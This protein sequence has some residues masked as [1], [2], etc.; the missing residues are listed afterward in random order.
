[1]QRVNSIVWIEGKVTDFVFCGVYSSEEDDLSSPKGHR[2]THS[3]LRERFTNIS[4]KIILKRRRMN[5]TK[6]TTHR[7]IWQKI[8]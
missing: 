1:M 8:N 7:K 2:N 4:G 6:A 3:N 5:E